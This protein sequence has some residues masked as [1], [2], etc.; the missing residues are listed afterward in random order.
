M[1]VERSRSTSSEDRK[2]GSEDRF[3]GNV[4]AT[5]KISFASVSDGVIG[6]QAV[7]ETKK[8]Q[9]QEAP[10]GMT[11]GKETSHRAS[12]VSSVLEWNRSLMKGQK[13]VT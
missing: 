13:H 11:L 10:R 2:G 6:F 1:G 12:H 7:R 5:T 3:E 9:I 8:F 4:N